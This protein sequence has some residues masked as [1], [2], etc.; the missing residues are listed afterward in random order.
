[1]AGP[2][3]V[4][5][6]LLFSRSSTG[7]TNLRLAL[8]P[9]GPT[10]H[11]RIEKYSLCKDV[12]KTQRHPQGSER[13]YLTPPLLVMNN[14]LSPDV[15]D[16]SSNA[17]PRHLESLSTTVFQS[18]FPPISPQSTPLSSIRRVLLLNRELPKSEATS[19]DIEGHQYII[20]VRHYAIVTKPTGL[21]KG[22]RRISAAERAL[23]ERRSKKN[24]PNLG[25]LADVADYILDP[26]AVSNGFTS[27]SESEGETDAEVEVMDTHRERI[28]NKHQ[29][30]GARE[31][32]M[33]GQH[34]GREIHKRAVK[35]VELGPRMILRMTKVEEGVCGGKVMWHEYLHKSE[36]EIK[37][38]ERVWAARKSEKEERKRI[39]KE[40]VERKRKVK[41]SDGQDGD[42]I[43]DDLVS[44]YSGSDSEGSEI[45]EAEET[46]KVG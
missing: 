21:S 1:M 34:R 45:A 26:S 11:F 16:A 5:H 4:S 9:R 6:L 23:K 31:S 46:M 22:I 13:E 3:G 17:V 30:E 42:D 8:L 38:M 40:N 39:Q 36:A 25:K 28:H 37:D 29:T 2:L 15:E 44:P 7:N 12:Q 43:Q 27:G 10:L 20:K 24:M 32:E 19:S 18:L 33:K 35:L 14:F 41:A